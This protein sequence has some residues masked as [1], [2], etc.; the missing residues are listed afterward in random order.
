[1]ISIKVNGQELATNQVKFSDGAKSFTIN[2]AFPVTPNNVTIVVKPEGSLPEMFFEI[3]Q[4][5]DVLRQINNRINIHLVMPYIPYARQDRPMVRNDSFSLRVFSD[6]L[7]RLKLDKVTVVDAHSDV[8]CALIRNVTHIQQ[9]QLLNYSWVQRS[10]PFGDV[11]VSPDAGS[12]KKIDKVAEVMQP[13]GRVTMSKVR[14]TRT[15]RITGCRISDCDLSS[16]QD[17]DC[18]IVD[19]ICD[20]GATFIGIAQELKKAGV[21]CISLWVTHGIFSRGLNALYESGIDRIF[22]TTSLPQ[23]SQTPEGFMGKFVAF[24][25]EH[26]IGMEGAYAG[27]RR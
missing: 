20:G 17:R 26:L 24:P 5:V 7:N 10:L 12:L 13:S 14:D 23:Y 9:H 15:G 1:M 11:L 2:G 27:V 25:I 6:L 3:A 18:L 22:T 8:S 4:A 19:D 16:L 21:K